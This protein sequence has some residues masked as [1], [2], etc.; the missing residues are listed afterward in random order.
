[1][2]YTY[3]LRLNTEI[4]LDNV[5]GC[6]LLKGVPKNEQREYRHFSFNKS[7]ARA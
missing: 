1:M 3:L 2:A 4:E 6:L 5:K 7:G